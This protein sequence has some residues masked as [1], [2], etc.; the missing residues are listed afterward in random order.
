MKNITYLLIA[1]LLMTGCGKLFDKEELKMQILSTDFSECNGQKSAVVAEDGEK[2]IVSSVGEN[3]KFEH[4]DAYFNCCL[5]DG[6][7]I[8][9]Y[10][11]N[12]T[13]YYCDS[14]KTRGNCKCMC[15]YTTLAEVG[16]IEN[17]DYVLCFISGESCKGTINLKFEKGMYEEITVSELTGIE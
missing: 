9:V 13:I 2:W 5:P 10:Q 1:I 16:N 12:D 14:E 11:S 6:I 3:F 15:T 4:I 7:E 17:N 8:E